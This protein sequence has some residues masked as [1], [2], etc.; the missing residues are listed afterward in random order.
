MHSLES[1]CLSESMTIDPDVPIYNI[2]APVNERV[3]GKALDG[4]R[5]IEK[6]CRSVGMEI[7]AETA[8]EIQVGLRT[9]ERVLNYQWL[10]DQVTGLR[11]L[12]EKESKGRVFLYVPAEKS[13]HFPRNDNPFAFGEAVAVAFP[14]AQ[15]DIHEAAICLGCSRATASVFH[16][17][18]VMEIA[19]GALGK[20]FNVSLA[21]TNWAPAI[22]E[23]ESK[24]RNMHKDPAWKVL[25][26]C[27]E[28]QEFYAQAASHFGILKDAWRN[29]TMHVRGKYTDEEAERIFENVK[30]FTQR[31]VERLSE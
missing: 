2:A 26:D 13:K 22:E 24:I 28:Q 12:F 30:G 3:R 17:M 27:K 4:L 11:K 18:R 5:L 9:G 20:K 23:I 14:S 10:R 19:L 29:Y 31:I 25:P 7:T 16:L 6:E 21:H 15:F 8:K 1:D